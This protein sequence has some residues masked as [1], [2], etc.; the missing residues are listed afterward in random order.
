[1]TSISQTRIKEQ[2][3]GHPFPAGGIAGIKL[4]FMGN[5]YSNMLNA[6]DGRNKKIVDFLKFHHYN[7][8]W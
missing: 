8:V 5:V 4:L 3:G 1:M 2:F 6:I 7:I